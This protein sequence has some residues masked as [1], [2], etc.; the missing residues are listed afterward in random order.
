MCPVAY[1]EALMDD[2]LSTASLAPP[3][4]LEPG[5]GQAVEVGGDGVVVRQL[6]ARPNSGPDDLTVAAPPR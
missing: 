6:R 1:R 4:T 2:F 5:Q 3:S